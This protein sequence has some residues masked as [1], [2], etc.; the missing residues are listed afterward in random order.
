MAAEMFT[1]GERDFRL[2]GLGSYLQ[3][4]ANENNVRAILLGVGVLIL[5]IVALD[6]LVWR[7]LLAWSIRFKLEMVE[8]EAPPT[9]WFYEMLAIR[10]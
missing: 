7:P 5:I 10:A 1:V 4:A 6:Q 3:Q 9:S 8:G 2:P